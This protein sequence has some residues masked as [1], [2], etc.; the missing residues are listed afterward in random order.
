MAD[1]SPPPPYVD[2]FPSFPERKLNPFEGVKPAKWMGSYLDMKGDDELIPNKGITE[3]LGCLLNVPTDGSLS[4]G[5]FVHNLRYLIVRPELQVCYNTVNG[6]GVL[7]PLAVIRLGQ[8][9]YALCY[10]L[11]DTGQTDVD[12]FHVKVF[13]CETNTPET[14]RR[15]GR[16]MPPAVGRR[17]WVKFVTS[18]Y[19]LTAVLSGSSYV[20]R[21][22]D[23]RLFD[24]GRNYWSIK[25]LKGWTDL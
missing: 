3:R 18:V 9:R 12:S 1:S 19:Y 24:G 17:D 7:D 10:L 6:L 21:C 23:F 15:D 14:V 4:N 20:V 25:R 13:E 11:V 16:L 22:D 2:T 8:R 5:I